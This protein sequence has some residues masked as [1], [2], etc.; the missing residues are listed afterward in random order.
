MLRAR[1]HLLI[2][3]I[4][5]SIFVSSVLSADAPKPGKAMFRQPAL[6]DSHLAF[7]HA[8]DLWTVPKNGGL[9][10]HLTSAKGEESNPRFSPDGNTIAFTANYEGSD[11]VYTIPAHGGA[12]QRVT[13]HG[14]ADRLLSWFPNGQS[15]LFASKRESFTERS[16]RFFQ[17]GATGGPALRLPIPY[18]EWACPSPES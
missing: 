6:S 16:S 4:V 15:L 14:G 9:A 2:A 17:I 7:I 13:F 11:D 3:V 10:T 18:G 5:A 8:G 12:P 1:F